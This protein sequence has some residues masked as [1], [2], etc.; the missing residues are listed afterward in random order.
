MRSLQYQRGKPP[1][2][3]Q[4]KPHIHTKNVYWDQGQRIVSPY[5]MIEFR[6]TISPLLGPA[7]PK[8][9]QMTEALAYLHR[10]VN[11]DAARSQ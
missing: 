1:A 7:R 8:S 6:G 3:G 4:K 10:R 5:L 2:L 9:R 11:D